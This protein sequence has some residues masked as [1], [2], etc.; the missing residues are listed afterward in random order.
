EC[1]RQ[2]V[3]AV[4]VT[5]M[6]VLRTGLSL[7]VGLDDEAAEVR[8]RAVDLVGL[9]SPPRAHSLVARIGRLGGAE[10]ERRTEAGREVDLD[11]VRTKYARQR[12][13]L[14]EVLRREDLRVGI[15]VGQNR[16]V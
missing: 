8:N 5:P 16:T 10:L 15:D 11:A 4:G 9:R 7:G 13:D 12:G 3:R 1:V 2:H 6:V 14:D